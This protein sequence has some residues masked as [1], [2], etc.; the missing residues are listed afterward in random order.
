MSKDDDVEQTFLGTLT[1]AVISSIP[2]VSTIVFLAVAIRVFRVA[3]METVTTAS[4]VGESDLIALLKGMVLTLLPGILA[5][6]VSAAIWWW[7]GDIPAP[8]KGES[9][10]GLR[11]SSQLAPLLN[12]RFALVLVCLAI[13]FFTLPWTALVVFLIPVVAVVILLIA[14][15]CGWSGGIRWA[16]PVLRTSGLVLACVIIGSVVM[17]PT[18]WLPVRLV[19][20]RDGYAVTLQDREVSGRVKAYVLSETDA[21]VSLLLDDPR[22]VVQVPADQIAPNPPLCVA[23][24]ASNRWMFVRASQVLGLDPDPGSPYIRC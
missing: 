21:Q 5:A 6:I 10:D 1:G 4:V 15:S 16:R 3:N 11:D 13:A 12:P 19:E 20:F 24:P 17:R 8:A 18:V 23:A 22:A 9:S 7:A 2:V 14:R